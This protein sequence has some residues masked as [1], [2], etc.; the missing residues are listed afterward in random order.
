[1]ADN[2]VSILLKRGSRDPLL[3]GPLLKPLQEFGGVVFPYTPQITYQVKANWRV[4]ELTHTNYQP[5]VYAKTDNPSISITNASF[6]AATEEDARYMF[7]VMHFFKTVTKMSF[8]VKDPNR[9]SPPPVLNFSGYGNAQFADVPVVITDFNFIL[10]NDV[11]YIRVTL[12]DGS[13]VNV[14]IKVD[15]TVNLLVNMP[16]ND[17]KNNFTL[18]DFASGKLIKQK[19]G[20]I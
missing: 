1:M 9:G 11:D 16:L 5:Q 6:T 13:V 8:G 20:Y 14:P 7:A 17:I 15:I 4:F 12:G 3:Q 18:A 2:R 10:P 19:K